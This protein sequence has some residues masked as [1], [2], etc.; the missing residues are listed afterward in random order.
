MSL[1]YEFGW[2]EA[3]TGFFSELCVP[4]MRITGD[5]ISP[6]AEGGSL[7]HE[8]ILLHP[9]KKSSVEVPQFSKEKNCGVR[10]LLPSSE[11][12]WY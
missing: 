6:S 3:D 4:E 9:C 1:W 12:L 11:P 10:H 7:F 5:G 2:G 8:W